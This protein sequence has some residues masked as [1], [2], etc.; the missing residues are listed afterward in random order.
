MSFEKQLRRTVGWRTRGNCSGAT[1][2][3]FESSESVSKLA[4]I[5]SARPAVEDYCDGCP[6]LA[7]CRAWADDDTAFEGV[8]AGRVYFRKLG[9]YFTKDGT[10]A[11]SPRIALDV[12]PRP[13]LD[14][15][16]LMFD[17][18]RPTLAHLSR[19]EDH[20]SQRR[21]RCGIVVNH[22][23]HGSDVETVM[24]LPRCKTCYR[25]AGIRPDPVI[26]LPS[27]R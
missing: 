21:A 16:R 12:V 2:D 5:V 26:P 19:L 8:A 18:R 24:S 17:S 11:V 25:L 3:V 7:A 6:V 1:P 9:D 10:L 14:G 23:Q 20:G 22:G 13:H 15:H 4:R 27:E